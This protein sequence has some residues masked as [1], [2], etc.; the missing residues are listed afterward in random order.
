[1]NTP[2]RNH[3]SEER[4]W[5]AQERARIA[6]RD[7]HADADPDELRIARALRRVPAM[8]LPADF[9]AQ[10][11]RRARA[12]TEVNAK[13]EQRLLRGLGIA[14]GASAAAVVAWYGRDWVATLAQTLPGGSNALNWS[15]AAALCLLANWG[16][17]TLR[18][19]SR[20]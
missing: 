17:N 5:Q 11:A 15:F 18:R 14:F 9:A 16:W 1:M 4:Q 13:F 10:V 2:P 12:Q 20:D 6:A 19:H 8:D 3:E 7:G